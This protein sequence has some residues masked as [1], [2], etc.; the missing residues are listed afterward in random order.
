MTRSEVLLQPLNA[1]SNGSCS[2][3]LLRSPF[4]PSCAAGI[5][6]WPY[7]LLLGY[8][9]DVRGFGLFQEH[10]LLLSFFYSY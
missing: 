8:P 2:P 4:L 10:I 6:R 9:G 1:H 5:I 7:K 3:S